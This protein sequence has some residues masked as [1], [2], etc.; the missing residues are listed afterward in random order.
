MEKESSEFKCTADQ[1][2]LT[3]IYRLLHHRLWNTN[4]QEPLE[5]SPK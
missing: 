4:S 2:E 5:L 3:D 1:K